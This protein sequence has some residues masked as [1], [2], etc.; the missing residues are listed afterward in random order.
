[1]TTF[2]IEGSRNRRTFKKQ[3]IRLAARHQLNAANSQI[4][5]YHHANKPIAKEYYYMYRGFA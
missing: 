2:S 4:H 3:G 5:G 1:M